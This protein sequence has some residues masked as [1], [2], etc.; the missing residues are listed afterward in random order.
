MASKSPVDH[1]AICTIAF[2]G[3]FLAGPPPLSGPRLTFC[4]EHDQDKVNK[5][6][7][8]PPGPQH[9]DG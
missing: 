4:S 9:R 2:A 5:Q 8:E 6:G 7:T 1:C 3:F